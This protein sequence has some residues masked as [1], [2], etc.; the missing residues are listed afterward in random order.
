MQ[1]SK[2]SGSLEKVFTKPEGLNRITCFHCKQQGYR[3]MEC[4]KCIYL[5]ENESDVKDIPDDP[6]EKEAEAT[7]E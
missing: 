4:P 2:Q 7:T 1:D 5:I 6:K 3:A